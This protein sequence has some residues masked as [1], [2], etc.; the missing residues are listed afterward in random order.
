MSGHMHS[1]QN[2]GVSLLLPTGKN[3]PTPT[4]SSTEKEKFVIYQNWLKEAVYSDYNHN[5]YMQQKYGK[6][7]M[8]ERKGEPFVRILG[9][10]CISELNEEIQS[11][12]STAYLAH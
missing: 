10:V 7:K 11:S 4:D 8:K 6:S 2:Y 1:L 3:I 9:A 12:C 5:K